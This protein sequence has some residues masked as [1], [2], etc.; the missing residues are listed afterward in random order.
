[1]V[2]PSSPRAL[3]VYGTL[4]FEPVLDALLSRVPPIAP[5]VLAGHAVVGLA[6]ASYPGLV[7]SR[8]RGTPARG[9][10]CRSL[11][12]DEWALID[13]W[14]DDFYELVEVSVVEPTGAVVTC[15]TYRLPEGMAGSGTWS[16]R[17]FEDRDLAAFVS[18]TIAWRAQRTGLGGVYPATRLGGVRPSSTSLTP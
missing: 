8:G 6:G 4:Q 9:F 12:M 13:A 16:A 1:M 17:R 18:G 15:L 3:F 2:S 11:E 5:G 7:V 14:E 10:V